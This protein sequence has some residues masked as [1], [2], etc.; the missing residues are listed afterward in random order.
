MKVSQK[1]ID[2]LSNDDF[3]KILKSNDLIIDILEDKREIIQFDN[4]CKYYIKFNYKVRISK[5]HIFYTAS[6][7]VSKEIIDKLFFKTLD[8][9]EF[10]FK[11][12]K[13]P[14]ISVKNCSDFSFWQ[15]IFFN[16]D[17]MKKFENTDICFDGA[18]SLK[19]KKLFFGKYKSNDYNNESLKK[20]VMNI[21]E[22][23]GINIGS[24][25]K[26]VKISNI[27]DILSEKAD[28]IN[29]LKKNFGE[30]KDKLNGIIMDEI[31]RTKD[32][33]EFLIKLAQ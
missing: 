18:Y 4:D 1:Y 6:I 28:A 5:K 26:I 27:N 21:A 24:N 3:I 31:N 12:A 29:M 17:I 2:N 20:A 16:D 7:I 8:D 13:H 22:K 10:Y 25:Y 15:Q 30:N 33:L 23:Y 14:S 11:N 9:A 19:K 32:Y